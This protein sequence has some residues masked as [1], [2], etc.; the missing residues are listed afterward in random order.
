M[1]TPPPRRLV[2]LAAGLLAIG[3]VAAV[4][5]MVAV[6]HASTTT[7][8]IPHASGM[9]LSQDFTSQKAQ[10]DHKAVRPIDQQVSQL[11]LQLGSPQQQMKSELMGNIKAEQQDEA[12]MQTLNSLRNTHTM[13]PKAQVYTLKSPVR[14][15]LAMMESGWS[16]AA[17]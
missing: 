15:H 8:P 1:T 3:V 17:Q 13:E 6:A 12:V 10:L 4:P 11:E 5:C 16:Q 9:V 2:G 7:N 14:E